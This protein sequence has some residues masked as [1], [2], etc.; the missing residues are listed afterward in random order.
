MSVP[1]PI[2][3]Q[4]SKRGLAQRIL[5][6]VPE[7]IERL[8]E[9]F[10]GSAAVALAALHYG[11]AK[12]VVLG[13]INGAL[14]S[15]W[16]E[17]INNPK[18]IADAYARLWNAQQGQERA[19]YN[20]VRTRFN[21]TQRPDYFLYLLA[22][23]VK[24]AVRYNSNGEFNQSPDN[25]RKGAHP[26]TMYRHI[27]EASLLFRGRV[28]LQHADYS[29]VLAAVTPSDIV[30]LDPPYQGVC[31][32]RDPRY[33]E[34]VSFDN[35]VEALRGLNS[36]NI[37]FLVS[38][39]GRTDSKTYGEPLPAFLQLTRIE[40][41]AGRSTQAT[42][43]G[44]KANTF[45]SLYLSAALVDQLGENFVQRQQ[46]MLTQLTIFEQNDVLP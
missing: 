11:K 13:D 29:H 21:Q 28:G 35:F 31:R 32:K 12:D 4:G 3:Y 37:S 46:A 9:P 25:R 33:R 40:L 24:A 42:L 38:Y 10:A 7:D 41:N 43:L 22:R 8:I 14:I 44:R 30:Y 1:H 39:D 2:P 36:A 26:N 18:S 17:I 5:A 20:Y 15:L 6:F 16:N 19:F 45:E 23:C 34:K 27:V